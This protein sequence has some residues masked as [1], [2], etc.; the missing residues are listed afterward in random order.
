MKQKVIRGIGE[1]WENYRLANNRFPQVRAL[2][3]AEQLKLTSPQ[4]EETIVEVGTGNGYLTFA[5]A[6]KVGKTGRIITYDYQKSNIDFVNEHNKEGLPITT[7]HQTLDY[8]FELVDGS[9]DKIST[10]ATL[11]HYDDR[12]KGT[13]TQGKEKAFREFYIILKKG[14][15]LIIGDVAQNTSSQRYFDSIDNPKY[16]YPLGHP[17]DFLIKEQVILFCKK[18]GFKNIHFVIENV[19]WQ[20][21]NDKEAQE[22]LRTIHNSKCTPKESLEHA[23][24]TRKYWT[25][26]GKFYLEWQLF[27]LTAEK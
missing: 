6:K 25:E 5:L 4:K 24:K 2:E 18:A 19:P 1:R 14:G 20:F 11:H 27:Y 15:K 26:N 23:K 12:L 13:G 10:M 3:L 21:E 17:H 16:C 8:N 7:I 9:V 22:F